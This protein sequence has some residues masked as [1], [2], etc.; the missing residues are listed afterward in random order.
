M[1]PERHAP[2]IVAVLFWAM[3][4]GSA[5]SIAASTVS[6]IAGADLAGKAAYAGVPS[7]L[8]LLGSAVSAPLWGAAMDRLGRRWALG[9]GLLAGVV[10]S[11][12][13]GA[14][15]VARSLAGFLAGLTLTG[16]AS[17]AVQLSRFAAAEVHPPAVRARAIANVVLGG[18]VGAVLGPILVGP[19]G[20]AAARLGLNE[21]VGPFAIGIGLYLLAAAAV[22][23]WLRPDPLDLGRIINSRHPDTATATGPTRTLGVIL[24]QPGALLA[25]S[26]MVIGQM[27]M[28]MLMVITSLHM[29]DSHHGLGSISAVISAHTLGMYAFS[30]VSGRWADR[31]GRGP[32]I[33]L[34][35]GLLTLAGFVAPLSPDVLPLAVS[36]FLLGL[37]WNLCFVG[38]SSLLADQLRVEER[39]RTQG[40]N[41]LLISLASAIGSLGSG[42]VFAAVGFTVM[43]SIGAVLALL[44]LGMALAWMRR[45]GPRP[46]TAPPT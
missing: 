1:D 34:G 44:P 40:V 29:R 32:V 26:A 30:V 6:P 15:L 2:R 13:V 12:I 20:A 42:V 31:W 18:T 41:D 39:G 25:V 22:L 10:G 5:A 24:R 45:Q 37:G 8:V 17:A 43:G 14:A 46:A 38:G 36:L 9:L 27:V 7:A 23:W 16:A 19:A 35:S 33:V 28:V 3:S 4:L 11:G 21:L